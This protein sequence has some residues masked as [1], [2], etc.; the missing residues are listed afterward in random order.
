M[1]TPY[2]G[3]FTSIK[4]ST[5][6]PILFGSTILTRVGH[7]TSRGPTIKKFSM[8][9]WVKKRRR[10]V[11]LQHNFGLNDFRFQWLKESD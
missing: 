4:F 6:N 8:N 1:R 10:L 7:K 11:I 2:K 5:T 9:I 3:H